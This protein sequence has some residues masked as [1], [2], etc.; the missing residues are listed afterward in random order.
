MAPSSLWA[1]SGME[2]LL[3]PQGSH[4]LTLFPLPKLGWV[5]SSE[6]TWAPRIL[7]WL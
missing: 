4:I 7:C 6:A 5:Y 3:C 1:V 2:V